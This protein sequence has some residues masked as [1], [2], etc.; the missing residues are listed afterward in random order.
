MAFRLQTLLELRQRA[1][2]EAER[3]VAEAMAARAKV[4][5][6]QAELEQEVV[7]ARARL[8]EARKTA[9]DPVA[10]AGEHLAR[11][12]FRKRLADMIEQR[13]E[14][15]RVHREGPLKQA[16]QAEDQARENHVNA[17]R[18]REALDKHKEREEAK[19]RREAERRAE[20]AASDLSI[21]AFSR[22]PR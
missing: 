16:K 22:K 19:V 12:R 13:K 4:E 6:R 9:A 18:E 5:K 15:A 2:E 7:K 21:A 1:E 14:E 20:D 10:Q 17:R 3:A 11:E 8:D